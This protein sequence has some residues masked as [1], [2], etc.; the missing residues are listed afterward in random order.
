MKRIW[1]SLAASTALA[2]CSTIPSDGAVE[3]AKQG[4]ATAQ[5]GRAFLRAPAER[6]NAY[7]DGM[8]FAASYPLRSGTP[9]TGCNPGLLAPSE[10]ERASTRAVLAQLAEAQLFFVELEK[11]YQ[12]FER[13]ASY[14]AKG[15]FDTA[16]SSL[17]AASGISQIPAAAPIAT[18]A[19]VAGGLAMDNARSRTLAESSRR[20][21]GV[22]IAY[23]TAFQGHRASLTALSEEQ[24]R[25]SYDVAQ[26]MWC[27]GLIDAR[28]LV[29]DLAGDFNMTIPEKL[30]LSSSDQ[31]LNTAVR[32]VLIERRTRSALS[33]GDAFDGVVGALDELISQ[34]VLLESGRP[35]DPGTLARQL[36]EVRVLLTVE[37]EGGDE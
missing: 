22:L 25:R 12:A 9:P 24:E 32:N 37:E 6:Q 33:V 26:T 17:E 15:E 27:A 20:I 8:T 11:T 3:L 31:Q 21:R 19:R 34:H 16:A 23:R 29:S 2:A 36:A 30:T 28:P 10:A 14:D 18:V 5:V 7:L 13:L 4:K 35:V 1:L